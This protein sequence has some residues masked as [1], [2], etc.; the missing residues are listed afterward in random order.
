MEDTREREAVR[1]LELV[2]DMVVI[3]AST[4][5]PVVMTACDILRDPVQVAST[6]KDVLTS[7]SVS[8][9]EQ[10]LDDEGL[11]SPTE[12]TETVR[13]VPAIDQYGLLSLSVSTE[14]TAAGDATDLAQRHLDRSRAADWRVSGYT[15]DTA[16]LDADSGISD[17]DRMAALMALLDGTT[18]VGLAMTV[19]DLPPWLPATIAGVYVEGGTYTYE[20]GYW[21]LELGIS[22]GTSGGQS[23]TWDQLDPA[24]TWE[25][26]DPAI[27]W[28]DLQGVTA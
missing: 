7:V 2:G 20:R 21:R 27:S 23:A 28:V 1:E 16:L 10:T 18:R 13:D 15:L 26:F 25:Q 12:R 11:P 8:W 19:I 9:R 6:V 5:A 4:A 14:L 3:V 17:A 24:W 22:P